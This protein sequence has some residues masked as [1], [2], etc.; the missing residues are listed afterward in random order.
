MGKEVL[1]ERIERRRKISR[2]IEEEGERSIH[3][4]FIVKRLIIVKIIVREGQEFNVGV[5]NNLDTLRGSVQL[6]NTNSLKH[7]QLKSL[8]VLRIKKRSCSLLL[9]LKNV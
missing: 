5:V 6:I 1:M 9:L 2:K 8:K 4:V 3:H 7:N